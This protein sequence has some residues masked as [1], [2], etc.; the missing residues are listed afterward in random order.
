MKY[1]ERVN[2]EETYAALKKAYGI[3]PVDE[4]WDVRGL[5]I[6]DN[7]FCWA[8]KDKSCY[9]IYQ[10][11]KQNYVYFALEKKVQN[12]RGLYE[13]ILDLVCCGLPYVHFN[14]RKGRY[15]IIRKSFISVLDEYTDNNYS[16]D[17]EWDHLVV[18]AAHPEN[19]TRLLKRIGR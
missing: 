2:R 7:D 12:I 8:T 10:A 13:T 14:G 19:I 3:L 6:E 17:P 5:L 1:I 18:Y 9:Y 4:F 11:N 16:K 15:D